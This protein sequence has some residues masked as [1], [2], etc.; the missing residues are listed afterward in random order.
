MREC[1]HWHD[2]SDCLK[3]AKKEIA[4]LR[5]EVERLHDERF[6][7]AR[8]CDALSAELADLRERLK[9]AHRDLRDA[10]LFLTGGDRCVCKICSEKENKPFNPLDHEQSK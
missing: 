10:V 6:A 9:E 3:C 2:Q 1:E 4:D 7:E 8:K 5:K